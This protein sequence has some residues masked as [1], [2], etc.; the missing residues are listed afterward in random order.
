MFSQ[1]DSRMKW[2]IGS[3][4]AVLLVVFGAAT[5]YALSFAD[6]ALPGVSIAGRSITGMTRDEAIALVQARA[7]A[8]GLSF[9][10]D[11]T[12]TRA[13]LADAGVSVDAGKTVDAAFAGNAGIVSR[14]T[15]L[16]GPSEVAPVVATDE[17]VL[18]TFAKRLAAS[19]GAPAKEAEVVLAPDG[20]SFTSTESA[21]GKEIDVEAVKTTVAAAAASLESSSASLALADVS[22]VVTSESAAATA[23]AANAIVSL[24]VTISDG[25]EEFTAAPV[26]K[27]SWIALRKDADGAYAAPTVDAAKATEWVKRTAEASNVAPV[28]GVNNVNSAGEVLT[29][30][31]PGVSGWT[32][33]NVDAVAKALVESLGASRPYSGEFHYDEV[34]PAFDT[35]Q[36]AEGAEN[37]V[38]Q[39]APDE[40]WVDVDLSNATVIAYEGAKVVGGPFY[41]VPGAPDTPT[42]TGTY[43][44]YLKYETQTMRGENADGTKYETPD[45][46][47]VTYWTG[48]YAFHGAPWR[49]SFGW[50]GP[51]GSHG[52][53]NMPVPAAKFIYDWSEIGTTVVSHY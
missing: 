11:G 26:D 9:D 30:A 35:R 40:K 42:V 13:S 25:I 53:V 52:C 7:E 29:L 41:M 46:P 21:A 22:P 47:W 39:A 15:A 5:A 51:G 36:V 2:A 1:H 6:R 14:F 48:S 12:E 4:L 24:G 18:S 19:T 45:V 34:K 38:Y 44:V 27:A 10:V 37:L 20:A 17:N 43:R 8:T 49:G 31:K 32:A 50:S 28:N 33:N 23:G 3:A 16:F